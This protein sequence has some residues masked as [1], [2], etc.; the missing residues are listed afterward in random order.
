MSITPPL[1]IISKTPIY[2]VFNFIFIKSELYIF[3][4]EF[5]FTDF[6]TQ[7][8]LS[9]LFSPYRFVENLILII[10]PADFRKL[11]GYNI[12]GTRI[13]ILICNGCL[14]LDLNG[15]V[16]EMKTHDF[17]DIME[18]D[19]ICLTSFS[20]DL[21]AWCLSITFEFASES[22]KNLRPGPHRPLIDISQIPVLN[23]SAK[24]C[25]TLE[26]QLILLE[27]SLFDTK[28]VYRQELI[29]LYF[30][31]FSLE[32][33]NILFT[34]EKDPEKT[35]AHIGKRDFVTLDFIKLISKHFATEHTV[36]FYDDNLC[37]STK[38]LTRI[39]KTTTGKTPHAI[40]YQ[41]IMH[42]AMEM[43]EDDK[44]TIG[45]IAEDLHFSDQAAFCKFFKKQLGMTPTAYRKR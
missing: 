31:S 28:H 39:I 19:K 37:L 30:R 7:K 27:N 11:E 45:Q 42:E 16:Y 36:K 40:L 29:R 5:F 22:L 34:R 6:M 43:L 3:A 2:L 35:P 21:Q 44:I 12:E 17:L 9:A 24:E 38:H 26:K 4:N 1:K 23:F 13:F 20:N 32:L 25:K 33:G 18:M 10:P 15:K 14:Q 41:K 8:D